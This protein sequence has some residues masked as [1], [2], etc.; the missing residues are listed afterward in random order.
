LAK[1]HRST[2]NHHLHRNA[3]LGS[4]R[5]D[6]MTLGITGIEDR[7]YPRTLNQQAKASV[8]HR[9]TSSYWHHTVNNRTANWN[10]LTKTLRDTPGVT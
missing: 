6:A 7:K 5:S 9:Q 1:A 10:V 3:R 2:R 8:V 4:R